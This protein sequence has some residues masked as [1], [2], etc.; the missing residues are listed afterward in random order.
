[1]SARIKDLQQQIT[2]ASIKALAITED[3]TVFKSHEERLAALTPVEKQIDA[4]KEELKN[5]QY[6]EAQKR[7]V[8]MD[9]LGGLDESPE[10]S[11]AGA[12]TRSALGAATK[13]WGERIE[14]VIHQRAQLA[15]GAKALI[16]GTID[17]PSVL[18]EV[19][20]M[21]G[22][23]TSLLQLIPRRPKT[24][25]DGAD[26]N[27]GNTFSYLRQTARDLNAGSV[28]DGAKKP[29]SGI[30]FDDAEDRYRVYAH[31]TEPMPK[32]FLDDYRNLISI[33]QLQLGQGLL[34]SLE[35][36]ILFGTGVLVPEVVDA[37]GVVIT[38]GEDP[39]LGILN[40][41]GTLTE[42]WEPGSTPL[43]Q[44]TNARYALEDTF[45]TPNAWLINSKDWQA[46]TQLRE[47]GAT[48]ALLF[49]SGRT[50]IDQFLG[51]YD[52]II[53]PLIPQGRALLGDF[54]QTELLIRED[55]HLDIDGSGPLFDRNQVKFRH[56]GRYGFATTKPSA[57]I[58]VELDDPG[59]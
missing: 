55:D 30:T 31:L 51:E 44:L 16:N 19:V 52:R 17:I 21:Q 26:G 32:R 48:G 36:D 35:R 41:P 9:A 54:T 50:S 3:R 25:G 49:G 46:L 13:S 42:D 39:V 5:L 40:T 11:Y 12:D 57:F 15:G 45:V 6:V 28:P 53:T 29:N 4:L 33:L 20:Q 7:S 1:M 56:E 37:N 58:E 23:P 22:R 8:S 34:E 14:R 10:R 27:H 59:A 43:Q 47:D 38:Q 2:D 18:R 24:S